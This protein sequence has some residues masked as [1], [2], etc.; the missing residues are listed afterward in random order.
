MI[1]RDIKNFEADV[2]RIA[3]AIDPG[4]L[5]RNPEEAVLELA[6]RL[7]GARRASQ[8]AAEKDQ[9]IQQIEKAIRCHKD[10]ERRARERIMALQVMAGTES[11]DDLR[12]EIGKAERHRELR[13]KIDKAIRVLEQDGDGR[14]VEDLEAE[15]KGIDLDRARSRE[16]GLVQEIRRLRLRRD[17]AL[18]QLRQAEVKF[19][20]V[21]AGDAGAIAEGARQSALAELR[22]I[23]ERYVRT[24]AAQ[25]LVWWAIDRHRREKQGPML[26]KAGALFSKLTVGSFDGLEPDYDDKDRPRL[27]G[28]R[29]NGARVSVEGMSEG[30]VDQLYLALRVAALDDYLSRG[31]SLP[32][33]ADDLF[34]NFDDHRSEAGLEILAQLAQEC[35]VICFTHHDHLAEIAKRALGGNVQVRRMEA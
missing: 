7:E 26:E 15:C 30:T 3:T 32:F 19:N 1:R 8:N 27:K 31:R 11:V 23:S 5:E 33:I 22:E 17:E 18:D 34:I 13:A 21:G 24:R 16:A 2:S 29:P 20:E 35:Q 9:R 4:L 10:E 25:F 28:R 12:A 14:S 6:R